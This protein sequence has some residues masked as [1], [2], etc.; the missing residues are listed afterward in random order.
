MQSVDSYLDEIIGALTPLAPAEIPLT[1]A[2]GVVLAADVAAV[3]PLPGFDNSAMDGYA[4]MAAD[5][6]DASE[7]NPVTLPVTAEVA[8]GDT[9]G[10]ALASGRT[11]KIMTGA[12]I[13]AD[14]DAVVPVEW[15]DGGSQTVTITRPAEKGHAIRRTGDDARPGDLLLRAGTRLGP[16]QIGV[17]AAAGHGSVLAHR[18]PKAA[19][20]STGNELIEPGSPL[21]PGLIWDSNSYMLAS[22]A[23][24]AGC[25][26]IRHAV[27]RDDP[28]AVL[29]A[30]ELAAATADLL[31]T[32]GGVSMGGEHD[33]VK[34][35]LSI[36]GTVAFRKVAMQPGM[37]QGFGLLGSPPRVPIFTLPGN[38]VSALVSFHV[39]VAPAVRALQNIQA[40]RFA[41]R[42]SRLASPA[43]SPAGRRSYLR[44]ILDPQAG[45]V[46]P[47]TGQGSHQ[48]ASMA[49]ANVL[50][51]MPEE[52][53]RL[54][55]GTEVDILDIP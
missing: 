40:E 25:D 37:P 52:V 36:L 38:P 30:I 4:V 48:I 24:Q 10:R 46:T 5:V 27:V 8:A 55:P 11:I 32:S 42:R 35:A 47:L 26:V 44:G 9:T 3:W 41:P 13:P 51:V 19:V 21:V 54:E 29:A 53:T 6:Q 50:I 34:A 16:A 7:D 33:A 15:T 14:A 1:D 39:F 31:I 49:R 18:R 22:A 23:R 17:L 20:I 28:A 45:T 43:S 2:D 12:L